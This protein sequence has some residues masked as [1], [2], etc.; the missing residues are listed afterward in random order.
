[1]KK[2]KLVSTVI[3]DLRRDDPQTSGTLDTRMSSELAIRGKR[4]ESF[5]IFRF[6]NLLTIQSTDISSICTF[7]FTLYKK[8]FPY[9]L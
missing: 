5:S 3:P 7:Y 8:S 4:V 9:V 1:M 6:D 2:I